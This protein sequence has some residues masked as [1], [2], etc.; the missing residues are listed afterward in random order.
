MESIFDTH[1]FQ[2]PVRHKHPEAGQHHL[3]GVVGLYP[4]NPVIMMR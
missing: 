2:F 4:P 3:G 1:T